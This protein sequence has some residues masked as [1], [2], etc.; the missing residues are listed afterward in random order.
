[1]FN[2]AAVIESIWAAIFG[3][4]ETVGLL[5][6]GLLLISGAVVLRSVL[7]RR[8]RNKKLETTEGV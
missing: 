5:A 4:P 3:I 6:F 2:T 1:M 7:N 8:D